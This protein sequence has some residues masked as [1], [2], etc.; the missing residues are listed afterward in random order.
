MTVLP[1]DVEQINAVEYE[2]HLVPMQDTLLGYQQWQWLLE[3]KS[4]YP[5]L[6][7]FGRSSDKCPYGKNIDFSG[8]IVIDKDNL[9]ETA[10]FM[11]GIPD[12]P[13]RWSWLG[14]G[15]DSCGLVAIAGK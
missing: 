14:N 7:D 1:T 15:F 6:L 4:D 5:A 10:T 8:I 2:H 11:T 9:R 12:A 13:G 3:H